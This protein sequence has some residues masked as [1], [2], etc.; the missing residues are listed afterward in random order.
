VRL[1]RDGC[2]YSK[3]G[4][5]ITEL[6]LET[7]R[8]P[9]LWGELDRDGRVQAWKSMD[10]LK[11]TLGRDTVRVLGAGP[12]DAAWKLRADHRSPGLP[13]AGTSCRKR[14]PG[15]GSSSAYFVYAEADQSLILLIPAD[16]AERCCQSRSRLE[17]E[18][19]RLLSLQE[20]VKL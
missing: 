2:R 16:R 4:V 12:K 17:R 20:Q 1:W 7:I 15:D 8:Q 13:P 18:L 14:A 9:A 19:R 10:T 11:A 5:M 3:C 6:L